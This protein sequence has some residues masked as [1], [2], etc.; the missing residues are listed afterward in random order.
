MVPVPGNVMLHALWLADNTLIC[1]QDWE[2]EQNGKAIEV[3]HAQVRVTTERIPQCVGVGP[4][5]R[6]GAVKEGAE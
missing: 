3:T 1:G 2:K 5:R 4:L 6:P